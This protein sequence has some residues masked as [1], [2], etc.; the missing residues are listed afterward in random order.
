MLSI[1]A[2][3]ST[4]SREIVIIP[5]GLNCFSIF[6]ISGKAPENLH[7]RELIFYWNRCKLVPRLFPIE[8]FILNSEGA[9]FTQ[10]QSW[11]GPGPSPSSRNPSWDGRQEWQ[12]TC[13]KNS[14]KANDNGKSNQFWGIRA[15]VYSEA[16]LVAPNSLGFIFQNKHMVLAGEMW[17]SH[18]LK[19]L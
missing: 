5:F 2:I 16:I 12:Q 19:A 10:A 15:S 13:K 7:L 1:M 17:Y 3:F 11:R 18:Q 6:L 14:S 4:Q 8:S 9:H